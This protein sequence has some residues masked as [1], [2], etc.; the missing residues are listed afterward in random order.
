M[1]TGTK[2]IRPP[3]AN[4]GVVAGEYVAAING[5]GRWARSIN[6]DETLDQSTLTIIQVYVETQAGE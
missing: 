1:G 3:I 2:S 4:C 6:F 5:D